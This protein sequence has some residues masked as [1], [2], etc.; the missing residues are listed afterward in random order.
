MNP[1]PKDPYAKI[2]KE[3][4]YYVEKLKRA[5]IIENYKRKKLREE[6]E[7]KYV[8]K[9]LQS[10]LDNDSA[11]RPKIF[12]ADLFPRGSLSAVVAAPGT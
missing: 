2:Y 3:Q 1:Q 10:N 7:H 9:S 4:K 11:P 8:L 12:I 5:E 6:Q